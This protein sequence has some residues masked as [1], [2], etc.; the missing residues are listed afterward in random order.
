MAQL[1]PFLK[2]TYD[3]TPVRAMVTG[4]GTGNFDCDPRKIFGKCTIQR[5]E[6]KTL[7]SCFLNPAA[8]I[9]VG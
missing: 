9:E 4:K 1:F 7:Q 2:E 5:E 3:N 6:E 8:Q